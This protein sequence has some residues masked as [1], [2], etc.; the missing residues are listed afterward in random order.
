MTAALHFVG[1]NVNPSRINPHSDVRYDHA[2][3]VVGTPDFIHRI[4]D[5]R[6]KSMIVPGDTVVFADNIDINTPV[7]KY[8]YD[9]S[10]FN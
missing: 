3:S 8:S 5:G 9:D 10:Q 4:W 2:V 7:Q 1:F 6:A